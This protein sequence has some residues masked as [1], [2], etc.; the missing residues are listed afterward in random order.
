MRDRAASCS[1]RRISPV[2]VGPFPRTVRSVQ[3][4]LH[5]GMPTAGQRGLA[6]VRTPDQS[7]PSAPAAPE[8]PTQTGGPGLASAV[9]LH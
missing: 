1:P 4:L 9:S 6:L 2:V 5:D 8:E 3:E 7:G